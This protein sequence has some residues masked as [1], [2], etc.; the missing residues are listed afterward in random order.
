MGHTLI[1]P[2]ILREAGLSVN[3]ERSADAPAVNCHSIYYDDSK[4]EDPLAAKWHLLV[5]Q[6]TEVDHH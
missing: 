1:A 4:F 2:V 6:H 5:I 3:E